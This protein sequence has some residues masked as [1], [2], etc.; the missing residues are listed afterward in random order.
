MGHT[1]HLLL[2]LLRNK[3]RKLNVPPNPAVLLDTWTD[4]PP[5]GVAF[6]LSGSSLSYRSVLATDLLQHANSRC[7]TLDV[8]DPSNTQGQ[9]VV[10]VPKHHY[11]RPR[12]LHL[13]AP[14]P[15]TLTW[16]G[17]VPTPVLPDS[18]GHTPFL[19]LTPRM[20]HLWR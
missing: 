19:V 10:E 13:P 3:R 4:G 18:V 20:V 1:V 6:G 9:G 15:H 17:L 5:P 16:S 7:L 11:T 2:R 14:Y 8:L 12:H